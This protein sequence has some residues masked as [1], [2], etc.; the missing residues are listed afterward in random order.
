MRFVLLFMRALVST[1]FSRLRRGPLKPSWSLSFEAVI[2]ALRADWDATAEWPIPRLRAEVN[3]RPYPKS[4][5]VDTQDEVLGGVPVRRFLPEAESR[6]VVLYF[7]GG[8]YLYGSSRTSHADFLARLTAASSCTV[9]GVEYR[10]A[11]EHPYPAQLEDA[12]A[13]YDALGEA[14]VIAGDSAGGNLAIMLALE[15]R[16]EDKRMPSGL[17]LL[18]PWSDLT[19]PGES[20]VT[21]D[22][23]DFGTRAALARHAE[24]FA[25]GIALDDPRLSPVYADL[26]GLPRTH[27]Q[28]GDSEIPRDDALRLVKRLREAGVDTEL[29]VAKDMPHNPVMFAAYHPEGRAALDALSNYCRS[30]SGLSALARRPAE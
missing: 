3:A 18:S 27:V 13:V 22:P 24:L 5:K 8:S 23:F 6:G 7:H 1:V 21:N 19:M 28:V 29:Y 16:D 30:V 12:L 2:R 25:S 9:I 14:P 10:L 17:A 11:P 4:V 15:L 26:R 20:F